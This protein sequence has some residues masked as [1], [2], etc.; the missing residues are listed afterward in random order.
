MTLYDYV[1]CDN[2]YKVRL[3]LAML[4][5]DYA[6][7]KVNVHP[8]RDC[9]TAEFLAVNPLGRIPVLRDG[10]LVL[11]DAQAILAYLAMRYDDTGR[12]WPTAPALAGQV[13]M[14]LAFASAELDCL[15][16]LRMNRI[17]S[18][19]DK[20]PGLSER[21]RAALT[22]LEDHLAEGEILGRQ[23]MIADHATIA[24][25]AI[26]PPTAL[27]ADGGITLECYPAIWRWVDRVKRLDGFVVMPGITPKLSVRP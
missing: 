20:A 14:W 18:A 1:L 23:W 2:C 11:R 13:V 9:E 3:L 19:K 4:R 7:R 17:T 27:A 25:I 8:G 10:D 6:S 24:D 22:V 16:V 5:L 26:F 12:W 15:S 21:A